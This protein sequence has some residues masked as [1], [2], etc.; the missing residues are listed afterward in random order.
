M[1]YF[2]NFPSLN[3]KLP[4]MSNSI[5][6]T[7][8]TKRFIIRDF[9]KRQILT[10]YTYSIRDGE[11]PDNVA[12]NVYGDDSLDWLILLPNEILD[13]SYEWPMGQQTLN[14]YIRVKYGSVSAAMAQVH[15]YEQIIQKRQEILNQDGELILIPEKTLIVDQTT[16]TSLAPANRTA[17]TNYDY[18]LAKNERRRNIS[19][20][21]NRAVPDILE[22]FRELY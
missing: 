20:I 22:A 9:Y 11:R 8:I 16:Y 13:P 12:Y 4:G 3:Y 21:S 2:S 1:K 19:I 14:E 6:V 5:D 18:E 10:F 15:H 7:D 17:I